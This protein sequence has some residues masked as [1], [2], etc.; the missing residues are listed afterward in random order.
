VYRRWDQFP[1]VSI[2]NDQRKPLRNANWLGTVHHGMPQ[3]AVP[4]QSRT[5]GDYLAFLGRISPEKRVDRAIAIARARRHAAEGR[6]EDRRAG[7]G[8][9]RARD[10]TLLRG[11]NVEFIGEIGDAEKPAFLG[12]AAALLFPIDWPE[13]F[14]IVMIEAMACGTPVVAWKCGSVPEVIDEGVTGRIVTSEDDAVAATREV[15]GYDRRA[16]R[17]TFERRFTARTMAERYVALYQQLA[18]RSTSVISACAWH[19]HGS[20][21][22]RRVVCQPCPQ[23]WRQLPRRQRLRRHRGRQHRLLPRRH[24]PAVGLSPAPRR[25][26]ARAAERRGHRG[27]RV[28]PRA[29]DQSPV[30]AARR[31]RGAAGLVHILRTRFLHDE[32]MYERIAFMNYGNA[33]LTLPV[34]I[35]LGA[36]FRDMFEVRGMV[37]PARAASCCRRRTRRAATRWSSGIAGWMAVMRASVGGVLAE[38]HR[39]EGRIRWNSCCRWCRARRSL[40]R[41]SRQRS[42]TGAV[43]RDASQAAAQA[44]RRMRRAERAVRACAATGRCSMRGCS[45]RARTWRC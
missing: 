39:V 27:Q 21:G 15:L 28:L 26:A 23:G 36:D 44:R 43:A 3:I 5:R 18:R 35:E 34:R 40:V 12:N 13:P 29:P 16:V 22:D 31:Q 24:A 2:S 6:R 38:A 9:L 4:V 25:H 19:E 20:G 37:R 10:R 1:L 30:A 17:A 33:P 8:V 42:G 32:R 14:G 41:R 11:A 7:Q 45:A